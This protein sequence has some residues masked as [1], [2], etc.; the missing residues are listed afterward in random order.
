[1]SYTEECFKEELADAIHEEIGGAIHSDVLKATAKRVFEMSKE[2][3][4]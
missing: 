1:M 2:Y 4:V 3:F